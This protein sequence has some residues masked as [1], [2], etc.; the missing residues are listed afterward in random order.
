VQA[1]AG[2][3]GARGPRPGAEH[4]LTGALDRLAAVKGRPA[5]YPYV[6]SGVGHGPL[7]ELMD[8]SVKWDM[9]NGIGVHMFGHGDPELVRVA[10]R[11]SMSDVV[12]QGNLQFNEDSIAFGELLVREA[13]KASAIRHAFITNSGAM[14]NE[15]ALKVCFQKNA[16]ASRVIAFSNCFMGRSTAM[17]QIGDSAGGRVGIPLNVLVDYMP[18]F[19]PEDP[20]GSTRYA[21]RR[22]EEYIERYPRQHACFV[23]ELVQGEGGFNV[24]PR[25]FFEPLMKLCRQHR[26]AVWADEVQT[27]GRTE[28]MYHYHHL[29]LGEYVDVVTIGKMSQV[30]AC[31]FTEAYAPKPG[32]LSGTFIGST[33]GLNVGRASLQRLLDGGYYGPKG[34]IAKLHASFREH[35]SAFIAKHAEWFPPVPHPH[36]GDPM[37]VGL[38]GGIGGMMR[39]TPFGGRKDMV[40]K[41]LNVMFEEGV[42]AFYCGHGPYHLRFLP[43]VGVM[44]PAQFKD[45]F[46]IME[47]SMA[48]VAGE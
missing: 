21:V 31:L 13:G 38:F 26:I 24:A 41:L 16:P 30:C 15:S 17:A 47:R 42:I 29:G 28:E 2:I 40:T 36:H 37:A 14:S 4:L 3:T 39:I 46:A 18:F 1:Q 33:V 25:E 44:Q 35:A 12:M 19:D 32:L 9:I 22:L 5:L 27:F 11:A 34:R 20:E 6:G 10:L 45:V 7:V 43:P 48:R 23:M 8:G